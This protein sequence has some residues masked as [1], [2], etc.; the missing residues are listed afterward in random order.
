MTDV[1]FFYLRSTMKESALFKTGV[2]FCASVVSIHFV[3]CKRRR[4]GFENTDCGNSIR[5]IQ[6]QLSC[7]CQ[8]T[9]KQLKE[10]LLL[11]IRIR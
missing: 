6:K 2:I 3:H 10:S 8:Q 4:L 7:A 9:S 5:V 1:Y 11:F